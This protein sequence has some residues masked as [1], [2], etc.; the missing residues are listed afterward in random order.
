MA[1]GVAITP[2]HVSVWT[3]MALSVIC[4]AYLFGSMLWP[5]KGPSPASALYPDSA[6]MGACT[7]SIKVSGVSYVGFLQP[8]FMP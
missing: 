8:T 2:S 4:P 1:T 6:L 3:L 7:Y 5:G